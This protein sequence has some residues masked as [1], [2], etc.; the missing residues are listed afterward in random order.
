MLLGERRR[1]Y[2]EKGG[3]GVGVGSALAERSACA[4][5]ECRAEGGVI[6]YSATVAVA[7][8]GVTGMQTGWVHACRRV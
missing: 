7:A 1:R 2:P 5:S 8:S 3:T 4:L 6:V